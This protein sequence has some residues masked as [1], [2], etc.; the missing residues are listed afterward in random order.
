MEDS[1]YPNKKNKEI[2]NKA[3]QFTKLHG[4]EFIVQGIKL[5]E[6]RTDFPVN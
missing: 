4:Y 1:K 5:E 6:E 3:T 2:R